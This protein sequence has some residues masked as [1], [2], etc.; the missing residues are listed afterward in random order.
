MTTHE[1][2][3][4][5]LAFRKKQEVIAV[6]LQNLVLVMIKNEA[7][8]ADDFYALTQAIHATVQACNAS[9]CLYDESVY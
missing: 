3:E 4:Q 1:N 9:D 8:T 2:R 6:A 5:I 7:G